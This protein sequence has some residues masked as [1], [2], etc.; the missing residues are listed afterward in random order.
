MVSGIRTLPAESYATPYRSLGAGFVEGFGKLV[1]CASPF[2]MFKLYYSKEF[3]PF[4]VG[5]IL[6]LAGAVSI[7]FHPKEM[8]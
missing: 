5:G 7:M 4:L 8:A 6:C 2:L 1:G 3:L